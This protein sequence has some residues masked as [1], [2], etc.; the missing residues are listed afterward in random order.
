MT[1]LQDPIGHPGRTPVPPQVIVEVDSK[2][3]AGFAECSALSLG[4][5]VV[6]AHFAR[7]SSGKGK[8]EVTIAI[9]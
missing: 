3:R 5:D 1:D 7:G 8:A 4:A 2:R 6:R 9:G